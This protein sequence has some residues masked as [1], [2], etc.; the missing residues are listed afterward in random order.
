MGDID[1]VNLGVT[2]DTFVTL[3]RGQTKDLK[4]S[5]VLEKELKDPISKGDV[6]GKLFYRVGDQDIAEYPL[7]ALN[8]VNEG[9]MFSRLIDYIMMLFQSWLN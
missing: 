9:G 5:F 3:P 2:E 4:E 8:N 7:V 1:Q 6:V